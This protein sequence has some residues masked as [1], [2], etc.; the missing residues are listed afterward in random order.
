MKVIFR[1]SFEQ[2]LKSIR[3][4]A[5]LVAR[6]RQVIERLEAVDTLGAMAN[7][8]RMQGWSHYYR[9]RIG[10]YRMGVKLDDDAVVVLRVLHRR[11]IYRRFP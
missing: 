1:K 5:D 8:K 11:E 6:L 3:G 10:D 7:V 2:D 4:N 9:I